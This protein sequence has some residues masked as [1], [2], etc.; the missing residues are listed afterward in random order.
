[1][2][3]LKPVSNWAEELSFGTR[4]ESIV[5]FLMIK[6]KNM[7]ISKAPAAP[8]ASFSNDGK[9]EPGGCDCFGGWG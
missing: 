2:K 3:N 6:K 9:E 8:P 5:G 1:M 4:K 7:R